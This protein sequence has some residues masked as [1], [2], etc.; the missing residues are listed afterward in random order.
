MGFLNGRPKLRKAAIVS[1]VDVFIWNLAG[2]NKKI[3]DSSVR[4]VDNPSKHDSRQLR[5]E[6]MLSSAK[7]AA[8]SQFWLTSC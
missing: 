3:M 4:I 8:V 2:K 5:G 7:C 1:D 6:Q